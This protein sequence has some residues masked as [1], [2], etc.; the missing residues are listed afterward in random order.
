M[1]PEQVLKFWLDD[2]EP[3]QWY[4]ANDALDEKIK[5]QFEPTLKSIAE[6]RHGMWLTYPSGVLA[7]I[8][9]TDQFS[10]NMYRGSDKSF[11]TD[12]LALSAAKQSIQYGFDL[13]IDAPA[14]QFFYMPLMHSENLTDQDRCVR[15]MHERLPKSEAN[16]LLHARAHRDVIR[17]FGRFPSRN[18]V[19]NRKDT[20]LEAAY[21]EQ[22]G[23]GMTL[24]QVA[25]AG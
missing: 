4:V 21:V 9:V 6:G 14:R 23:Y 25:S 7:Y 11:A 24:T 13:R 2:I 22:G 8:I 12:R 16:N 17:K 1:T 15:L 19:L 10:R 5:E 18:H 3:S 20:A